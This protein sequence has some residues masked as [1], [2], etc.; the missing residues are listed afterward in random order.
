M[1]RLSIF[2]WSAPRLLQHTQ[3]F[4][5]HAVW[6]S[7]HWFICSGQNFNPSP[8]VR[9]VA[10]NPQGIMYM[11]APLHFMYLQRWPNHR[12]L[13]CI[14]G[15]GVMALGLLVSSF[16][17]RVWHLI[18][19][20]GLLYAIGG[21]LIYNPMLLFLDE[22]FVRRKG[23]AFGIMWVSSALLIFISSSMYI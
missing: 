18:L 12:R 11:G 19:T 1:N 20:Q 7:C 23:I 22:W 6:H 21:A 2:I 3:T 4:R 5:Y 16:S 10:Y 17:E 9:P 13:S 8:S 15:V 14:I